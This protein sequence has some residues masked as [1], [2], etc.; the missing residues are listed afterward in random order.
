MSI[1][2]NNTKEKRNFS[3]KPNH[4]KLDKLTGND[5]KQ[6]L[7]NKYKRFFIYLR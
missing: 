1:N 5:E 6:I 2:K 7:I 4:V 3:Y